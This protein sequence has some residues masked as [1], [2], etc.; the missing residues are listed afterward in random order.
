MRRA[1]PEWVGASPD[2]MPPP[3]VRLRIFERERG[4][5]HISGRKIRPGDKWHLDH[6]IAICNGGLNVES[7]MAPALH[8]HH[9][10]KTA[11][12]VAEKSRVYRKR[13]KHLGVDLRHGPKIKSA[14]FAKRPP[15]RTAS[16]PIVRWVPNS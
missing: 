13:A 5:C 12:D 3:R 15:P 1:L 7:N 2:A 4:I 16:R 14:G 11:K 8:E 9:K 10:R 6:I